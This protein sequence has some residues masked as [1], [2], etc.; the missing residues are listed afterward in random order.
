MASR[1]KAKRNAQPAASVAAAPAPL[2][3]IAGKIKARGLR[4]KLDCHGEVRY[5]P[6]RMQ[7]APQVIRLSPRVEL[8]IVDAAEW[9][10]MPESKHQAWSSAILDGGLVAAV[11]ILD[12][13]D[14][15]MGLAG[16]TELEPDD[17]RSVRSIRDRILNFL[18][19]QPDVRYITLDTGGNGAGLLDVELEGG[20]DSTYHPSVAVDVDV[21]RN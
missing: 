9:V 20:D 7:A 13:N 18:E 4:A 1:P 17:T 3:A 10:L 11:R 19:S 6:E 21:S 8:I 2:P 12:R 15:E 16:F 5:Y 14:G